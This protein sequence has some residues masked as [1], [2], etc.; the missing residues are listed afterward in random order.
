MLRA[1]RV[2]RLQELITEGVKAA[3]SWTQWVFKYGSIGWEDQ[4]IAGTVAS[5]IVLLLY[6]GFCLFVKWLRAWKPIPKI[7]RILAW[8]FYSFFALYT[9]FLF[10]DAT[11]LTPK[12]LTSNSMRLPPDMQQSLREGAILAIHNM[13]LLL[14]FVIIVPLA[15]W[16]ITIYKRYHPQ[17]TPDINLPNQGMG[18]NDTKSS[19]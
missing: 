2:K 4:I 13:Y 15:R 14:P 9:V 16:L 8:L 17:H 11:Q 10:I 1:N 12:I 6:I 18:T 7:I 19:N 3:M 5:I